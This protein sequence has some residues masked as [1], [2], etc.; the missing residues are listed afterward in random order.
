MRGQPDPGLLLGR[1]RLRLV[2]ALFALA[3]LTLAVRLADLTLWH[4][5]SGLGGGSALASAL[6]SAHRADIVDRNG[7]LLATDYPKTSIYADPAL[8]LDPAAAAR[9]LA[10]ALSGVGP[11][12]LL[13]RLSQPRRF[14]WLKRHVTAAEERAV[15]R[16]GLP[17]VAFRT[18]L[19][20][21]YPQ[22]ELAAHLVGY[23][24]VENQGLAGVE[25]AFEDRLTDPAS[26]TPLVLT[27]DLAVQ[28]VVRSELASARTRFA[29]KGATAIVLDV[30]NGEL[31]AS[32][33]L[34]DF[35]PHRYQQASPEALFNRNTLG[36]YELGSLF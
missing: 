1:Q 30:A 12:E 27:L 36:T 19:H 22:R 31:L 3:L 16:L 34:P 10:A 25:R 28:E 13:E 7:A 33:S 35:D 14:I 26:Q 32:V 23:V 11:A 29:A 17:G 20:R 24:G 15:V 18:E 6:S 4:G 9:S 2:G 5:E 21:I 8:V